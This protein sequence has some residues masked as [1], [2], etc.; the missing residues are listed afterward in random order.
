MDTDKT[1]PSA[2]AALI[3][4]DQLK[5]TKASLTAYKDSIES[6]EESQKKCPNIG[7]TDGLPEH[8][9]IFHYFYGSTDIYICEFDGNNLM[10]GRAIIGGDLKT[11]EWGYFFLSDI[12]R[13]S[14]IN[15]DYYFDELSI[16][17]AFYLKFPNYFSKPFSLEEDTVLNKNDP[18][19]ERYIKKPYQY[20]RTKNGT[21]LNL[22]IEEV[23]LQG[24]DETK[25]F[26]DC[27]RA[28]QHNRSL[29][30]VIDEYFIR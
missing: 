11:S 22:D 5:V 29:T 20:T 25:F 17:A 4:P 2:V 9:A 6:L 30:D 15:I 1:I 7:E 8:P 16:E 19:P 21:I 18:L 27:N 3:P 24:E 10:Y 26:R 12:K 28:K 14:A 13:L 23:F